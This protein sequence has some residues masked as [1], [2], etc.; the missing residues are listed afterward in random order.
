MSSVPS[1]LTGRL[2]Y[3]P[4]FLLLQS[5]Y[6]STA[7]KVLR[8]P[9]WCKLRPEQ[10]NVLADA[11]DASVPENVMFLLGQHDSAPQPSSLPVDGKYGSGSRSSSRSDSSGTGHMSGSTNPGMTAHGGVGDSAAAVGQDSSSDADVGTTPVAELQQAVAGPG[12]AAD[13][14]RS[15]QVAP[16]PSLVLAGSTG[17]SADLQK[18]L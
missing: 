5:S 16:P 3:C 7:Q 2:F 15:E 17:I 6:S 18:P 9:T 12:I 11:A 14:Q 10:F 1:G 13:P 4:F 8:Q